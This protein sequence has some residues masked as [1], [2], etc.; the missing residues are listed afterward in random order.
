MKGFTLIET[1]VYLALLSF[2]LAN[3]FGALTL[4]HDSAARSRR[5]AEVLLHSLNATDSADYGTHPI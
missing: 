1:V 5:S 4:L 3:L 2:M